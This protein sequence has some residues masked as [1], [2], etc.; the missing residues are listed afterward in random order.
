MKSHDEKNG[1]EQQYL[2]VATRKCYRFVTGY[3]IAET[4][5]RDCKNDLNQI[6][7]KTIQ[8]DV[9]LKVSRIML[10]YKQLPLS[11]HRSQ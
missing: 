4:F 1:E 11:K 2:E 7:R 8:I 5:G 10:I 9:M 3:G 6:G